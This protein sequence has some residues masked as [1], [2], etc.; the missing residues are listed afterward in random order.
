MPSSRAPEVARHKYP[1]IVAPSLLIQYQVFS[2]AFAGANL[3]GQA[4]KIVNSWDGTGAREETPCWTAGG[5]Q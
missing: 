3:D 5:A 2:Q 4:H 1:P